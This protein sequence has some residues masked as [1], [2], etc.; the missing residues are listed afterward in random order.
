M[1]KAKFFWKFY[2]TSDY[3]ILLEKYDEKEKIMGK[4]EKRKNLIRGKLSPHLE[5][6]NSLIMWKRVGDFF[7]GYIPLKIRANVHSEY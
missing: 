3:Y 4:A 5:S 2:F 1:L 7:V 6:I